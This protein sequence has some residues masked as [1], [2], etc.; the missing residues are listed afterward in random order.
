MNF[1][2]FTNT[3]E[4]GVNDNSPLIKGTPY[5]LYP[6]ALYLL[7]VGVKGT[8]SI[9]IIN[10]LYDIGLASSKL[11]SPKDANSKT[12]GSIVGI[13][14]VWSAGRQDL[15]L[16]ITCVNGFTILNII[17]ETNPTVETIAD[18]LP[19]ILGSRGDPSGVISILF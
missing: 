4:F 8:S 11:F 2:S 17:E 18:A 14:S 19:V 12:R 6:I 9:S 16:S 13:K 15:S 1:N 7:T 3:D 10:P 5:E